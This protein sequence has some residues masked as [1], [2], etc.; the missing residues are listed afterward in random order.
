MIFAGPYFPDDSVNPQKCPVSNSVHPLTSKCAAK[1]N[2]YS[3]LPVM[4]KSILYQTKLKVC[5]FCSLVYDDVADDDDNDDADADDDDDDDDDGVDL[6]LA[7][8]R[9]S[10]LQ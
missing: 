2:F 5:S 6:K 9:T 7:L 3:P 8:A 1:L 10:L 4:P